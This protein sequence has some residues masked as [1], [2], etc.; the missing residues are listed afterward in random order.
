[1]KGLFIIIFTL[2]FNVGYSQDKLI[3]KNGD[4]LTVVIKEVTPE[5]VVFS[6]PNEMSINSENKSYISKIIYSGGRQDVFKRD[7]PVINGEED[8]EKVIITNSK[9]DVI[10]LTMIKEVAGKSYIGGMI[11]NMGER[12]AR[13]KIKK[14]AA[15]L[16]APIVYVTS[17]EKSENG[18]RIY[19]LAYK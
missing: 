5:L 8:W 4:T 11:E 9:T 18:T 14:E 7:L 15:A 3:K 2:C 13:E 6:Y 1:M 16:K 17:Y 19:G 12:K 10:G